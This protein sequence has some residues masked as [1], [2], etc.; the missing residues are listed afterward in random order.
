MKSILCIDDDLVIQ[1]MVVQSLKSFNVKTVDNFNAGIDILGKE[2]FDAIILDIQLGDEDGLR[3]L[4]RVSKRDGFLQKTVIFILS[5]HKD[6]SKKM[7]AFTLGADDFITKPFDPLE[8]E[9]RLNARLKKVSDPSDTR[10]IGD[11]LLDFQKQKVYLLSE[12]GKNEICLTAIELKIFSYLSAHLDRVYTRQQIIDEVW[13]GQNI[14][15]RTVDSHI[16]HLRKKIK[17][18]RITI[19]T[20]NSF[21]YSAKLKPV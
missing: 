7:M 13:S 6:I 19:Q 10:T 8:L 16:A 20:S 17:D 1:T 21:G 2:N 18:S 4:E 12:T 9:I 5:S 3:L 14:T 15:E 11:I